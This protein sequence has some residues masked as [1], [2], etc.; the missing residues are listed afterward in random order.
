MSRLITLRRTATPGKIPSTA[1]MQLGE[2]A[3]NTYDGKVYLKKN[4]NGAETIVTLGEG[5][6]TSGSQGAQ[7]A[8]GPSGGPGTIGAQGSTGN[9]GPQGTVGPQGNQ[10]PLGFQGNQEQ[11][12]KLL[13]QIKPDNI[14][15][16]EG[17]I[18]YKYILPDYINDILIS[19]QDQLR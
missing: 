9:P 10:G 1:D 2:L 18:K 4:V 17:G 19:I 11:G 8:T 15:Y 5:A 13:S 16:A 6:T 7:G 12:F 14:F 3:I